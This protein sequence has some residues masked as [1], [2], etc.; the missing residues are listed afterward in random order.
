[1]KHIHIC[2]IIYLF[3]DP[4]EKESDKF[5]TFK[6]AFLF[7]ATTALVMSSSEFTI[8]NSLHGKSNIDS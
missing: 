4:L 8:I 7:Q 2:F 3:T 1:M 5:I 6:Y